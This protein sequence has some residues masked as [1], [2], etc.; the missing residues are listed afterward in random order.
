MTS[1]QIFHGLHG[2]TATLHLGD[3]LKMMPIEADIVLADPPYGITYDA[4]KSSQQ[5]IQPFVM[6]TG[7]DEHFEPSHLMEYPDVILWGVNNY[8]DAI[9]P[10]IGQ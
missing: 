10:K 6:V 3:C 4:S 5:G 8:C 2:I 7:D 9:P 1:P